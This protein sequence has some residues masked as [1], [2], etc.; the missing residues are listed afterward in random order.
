M[1]GCLDNGS[2]ATSSY[3]RNANIKTYV[4]E[5]TFHSTHHN[6]GTSHRR[7]T[8]STVRVPSTA[9][10]YSTSTAHVQIRCLPVQDLEEQK[11]PTVHTK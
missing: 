7:R 2:L 4:E 6:Y 11:R 8:T 9:E 5:C 10:G 3:L 1:R